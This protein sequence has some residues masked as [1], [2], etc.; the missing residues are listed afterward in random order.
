[1]K[2]LLVLI[3]RDSAIFKSIVT[4]NNMPDILLYSKRINNTAYAMK[5]L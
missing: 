3:Q 2:G 1:M 4:G 5:I